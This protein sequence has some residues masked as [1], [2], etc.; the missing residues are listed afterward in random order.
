MNDKS[1]ISIPTVLASAG[2]AAIVSAIVVTIG[3]V[4]V[5][6]R[7]D[8]NVQ[9]AAQPTVVNLGSQ[10]SQQQS[11]GAPAQAAQPAPASESV[12]PAAAPAPAAG[13]IAPAA[14]TST[15]AANPAALTAPQLLTKVQLIM[16]Q[17]ASR[18]SRADELQ[19]GE[20]AL[21]SV[22]QV[23]GL[24]NSA[25]AT[26]FSYRVAQ[27]TQSGN[28]LNGTLVMSLPGFGERTLPLSWVWTDN[29]WKLTNRS[30]C[31]VAT[32]A[33]VKCSVAA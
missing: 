15:A 33:Q 3:V 7:H 29:K 9:S 8:D 5:E 14:P 4:G 1:S 2:L 26:G 25:G 20:Q 21:T 23:A 12:A 11:P 10:T 22:N 27:V 6:L 19:G 30:V 18:Q 17:N 28:T 13:P 32:Y 24:L 31:G 16:N